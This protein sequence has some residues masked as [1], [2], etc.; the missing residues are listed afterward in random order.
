[1]LVIPRALGYSGTQR[2]LGDSG[3]QGTLALVH[4]RLS[5][6]QRALGH[7]GTQGTWAFGRTVKS[8]P[9]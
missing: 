1:M 8:D 3:I 9:Y 2:A 6:T 7:S 5:G 4:S